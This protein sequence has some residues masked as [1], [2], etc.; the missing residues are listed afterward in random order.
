MKRHRSILVLHMVVIAFETHLTL[1]QLPQSSLPIGLLLIIERR[2][3]FSL[4]MAFFSTMKALEEDQ[5]LS[6]VK[7]REQ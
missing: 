4:A 3:T 5:H 7:S 2:T 6:P 1:L